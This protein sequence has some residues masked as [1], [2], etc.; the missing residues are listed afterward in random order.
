MK[1]KYIYEIA[2][3]TACEECLYECR[4]NAIKM[5]DK[6]AVIDHEKCTACGRCYD[7][8]PH[9]AIHRKETESFT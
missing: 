9:G 2:G 4:F 8:C 6:G 3:C 1:K 5:T 7:S